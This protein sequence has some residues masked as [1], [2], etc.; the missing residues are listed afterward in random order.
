MH[1]ALV[2]LV[3]RFGLSAGLEFVIQR[4]DEA[5]YRAKDAGRNR[6]VVY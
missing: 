3:N 2:A 4:V 5:V 1:S 6:V